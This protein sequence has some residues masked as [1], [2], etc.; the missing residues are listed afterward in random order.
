MGMKYEPIKDFLNKIFRRPWLRKI[1]YRMIDILLLRTWHIHREIKK[2]A[3]QA[4]E[5]PK[6]L[7]AGSGL[8][9]HSYYLARKCPQCQIT[10]VDVNQAQVDNNN[11]FFSNIG[12]GQRVKFQTGRLEEY[13]CEQCYDL[14]LNIEV[15]EHIEADRRV[16]QNFY[17]S[18]R[19]GGTLILSTPS[20]YGDH[21]HD[22]GDHEDKEGDV[23]SFVDEH[24]RDGYDPDALSQMLK[25]AGFSDVKVKFMYGAYGGFAWKLTMKYP[26]IMLNKS[27]L[28]FAVLPFYYLLT[29]PVALVLNY[30]DTIVH[31]PKGGSL[32]VIARK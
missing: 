28:F 8:G 14:I 3:E 19:P 13:V 7:D 11:R 5:S 24:V 22:H 17:H 1:F 30:L 4:P 15:I 23:S 32:L 27:F 16:I 25:E 10:G 9:Q 21:D 18:L 12:L 29:M 6:V 31:N 2:W 20:L 26:I